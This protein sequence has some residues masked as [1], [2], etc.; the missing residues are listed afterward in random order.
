TSSF[1]SVSSCSS[2]LARTSRYLVARHITALR[3]SYWLAAPLELCS[4]E[5]LVVSAVA[6]VRDREAENRAAATARSVYVVFPGREL[7]RGLQTW[8]RVHHVRATRSVPGEYA[9]WE[10]KRTVTP[11]EAG[12][13]SAF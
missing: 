7:D 8:T 4:N 9:I 5:R 1:A 13:D 3:A 12:L 2:G 6:P 11:A 10:F